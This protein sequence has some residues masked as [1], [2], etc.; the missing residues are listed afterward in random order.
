M[1][2]EKPDYY[3]ILCLDFDGVLH[4]YTSGWKG[5]DKIPD[6]P[7]PGAK[8]FILAAMQ[9][10]QVV[11]FSSRS[12]QHGGALAMAEYLVRKV[13][14]PHGFIDWQSLV[15][16]SLATFGQ[17]QHLERGQVMHPRPIQFPLNK[18]PAFLTLDDRA[19]TF[20]GRWPDPARLAKFKPWNKR[21][22]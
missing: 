16:Q 8:D 18:P 14:I 6:P 19:I 17:C 5:A 7:V 2:D 13:G 9:T 11:V 1:S 22:D 3:P 20:R 12:H 21:G 15:M 4:Q 10:F